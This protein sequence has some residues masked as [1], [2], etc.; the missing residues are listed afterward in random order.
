MALF[1]LLA[2][3]LFVGHSLIGADLPV[4]LQAGLAARGRDDPQVS[5][6]FIDG[7]PLKHQW[8]HSA[9]AEGTDARA[10]LAQGVDVLVLAEAVPLAAQIAWNDSPG[11]VAD[12]AQGAW[13]ANPAA[14]VLIYEG[15]PSLKSGSGVPLAGDPGAATP[16]AE[17]VAQD[18]P[19]WEGLAAEAD[20]ARPAD[21]PPLR[22][23]PVAQAFARAGQAAAEGRIPGISDLQALFADDLHPN[24][25]GWYLATMVQLAV[26]TDSSPEGLPPRLTRRWLSRDAVMD[27][28]TARALQR[29][30]WETVQAQTAREAAAAKRQPPA[31]DPLLNPPGGNVVADATKAGPFG[32]AADAAKDAPKQPAD[33]VEKADAPAAASD[34]APVKAAGEDPGGPPATL[35]PVT[36]PALGLGLAGVNDWSVQ[37]P[38]IDVMKT[39]RGWVGHTGPGWGGMEHDALQQGGWLDD[40]GWPRALPPGVRGI[41]TL[42]LTDQPESAR[43][44]AGRYHLRWQ[45]QGTIQLDGR[46]T[47]VAQTEDGIA[48][49]YTPGEGFV[50]LTLT[51]L[52][53]VD[54]IHDLSVVR[55][56][57]LAA[58]D[59]GAIFNPD[60]LARI[61]GVRLIRFMDWMATNDSTLARLADSPKIS[62]YTW[63]RV[64]V[65]VEIMLALANEL[66]ADPWFTLPHLADDDLVRFYAEAAADLLEPGRRAWVELSNEVWNP[67]FA[68][69]RW[70]EDQARARWGQDGAGAQFYA[71]RAVQVMQIW[72]Q[73]FGDTAKDR[74]VRVI[75]TQTGWLGR[76]TDMLAAPLMRAEGL[77]APAES[78]DAYAVTGYFAA[79]LG[80]EAKAA[81]LRGWLQDSAAADQSHPF[82]LATT[83]A[84]EELLDGRHSGLPDDTLND[85]LTRV[86]PWHAQV[87]QRAGLKLVMYEGGSHVVGYGPMIEDAALTAFFQHLN[88]SPEM[89]ALYDRLLRGWAGLTD[90]PFNAFVDVTRPTKWGSWGALRD[91]GDDNPRWQALAKGCNGC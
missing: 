66:D 78:F 80:S 25:K 89:G 90:A 41:S 10:R 32:A 46:A 31:P 82:A 51:E 2:E 74:L 48:F 12:W 85:V 63:G 38:F 72:Q 24:G 64:G 81:M 91:L 76:E 33:A 21:A 53:P 17:R 59:A 7:A 18:L 14:Q 5:A 9:E 50:L 36:N 49:D 23:V 20:A 37:Q 6:Q 29:I 79:L 16:W 3:I 40:N 43:Y 45:G 22:L 54:P 71:L 62:D 84:A 68:Q 26:L 77:P 75:A 56:D 42:I 69:A 87:A 30:A 39:A 34:P 13:A 55:Q 58:H 27:D 4:L 60:W 8:E 70:A 83:R 67:Q 65:P 73:A 57:R 1:P 35:T 47:N 15:W 11:L 44:L 61:R 88:Y 86:L 19:L 28:P 52:D